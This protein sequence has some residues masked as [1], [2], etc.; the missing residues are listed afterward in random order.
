[1]TKFLP[2][3]LLLPFVALPFTRAAG[4]E[5]PPTEKR[6]AEKTPAD[7]PKPVET[8]KQLYARYV[9]AGFSD[10]RAGGWGPSCNFPRTIGEDNKI[11]DPG[12]LSI[13]VDPDE[14]ARVENTAAVRVRVVNRTGERAAFSAIDSHLYLLQEAQNEK[15]EWKPIE[16]MPHGT[17]PRDCAVGFHRISLQAGQYWEILGPRYKGPLKTKLRFRLDLGTNKGKIPQPGGEIIYSNE[18][19]GSVDPGQFNK[20]SATPFDLRKIDCLNTK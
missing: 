3:L 17:G 12:K 5:D 15:G 2:L 10:G 13:V 8:S 7:A 16:K 4:G 6:A 20:G 9:A 19:D 1:M 11:G 18:F 14:S